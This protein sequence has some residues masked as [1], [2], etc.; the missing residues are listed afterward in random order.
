MLSFRISFLKDS[1]KTIECNPR[2]AL[3]CTRTRRR[4]ETY[5]SSA[6]YK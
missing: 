5:L 2:D 3:M 1:G 4:V 6:G